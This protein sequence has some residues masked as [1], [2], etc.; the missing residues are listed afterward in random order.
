MHRI[1]A[2]Q[3]SPTSDIGFDDHMQLKEMLQAH[4]PYDG[5]FELRLPGVFVSRVSRASKTFGHVL[6]CPAICLIAQGSKRVM[7]G[8]DMFDYDATRM[9]VYSMDVP[10]S[11]QVTEASVNAPYLGFRL[12]M[13][14]TR[15]AELV[16]RVYPRGLPS[17][18]ESRAI[19]VDKV[20]PPVLNA[21]V[22]LLELSSQPGQAE[23]LAPLVIDEIFIRL[24]Q[25]PLGVRIAQIGLEESKIHRISHAV[26]WVRENFDK[27]LDVERLAMLVHMSPSSFHQHFKAITSLSPLQYQKAFRLQEA[28]H[29]ML[30]SKL[31]AASASQKVGYQ[32]ASQ[33]TRE[34][35]RFFGNPPTKDIALLRQQAA[36]Q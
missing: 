34:Y 19:C 33:F 24:L 7:L 4:T 25:G 16:S 2:T 29:L 8:K 17:S 30:L 13:E 28:R 22:R 6:M 31:D 23:L 26:S 35:G 5:T 18:A 20:D 9:M 21:V 11:A 14:P 15:I 10:V 1:P 12:N 27:P 32:S 36:R 3:S